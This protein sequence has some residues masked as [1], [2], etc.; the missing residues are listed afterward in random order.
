MKYSP[1]KKFYQ[2]TLVTT[3]AVVW[4]EIYADTDA[5]SRSE[6]TTFAVVWI[7]MARSLYPPASYRVTTFA[8]VWIEIVDISATI[9]ATYVTTF[10]VVW[11]EIRGRVKEKQIYLSPPSRWCGL[12]SVGEYKKSKFICHH[13]RGGVD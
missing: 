12:K 2:D 11:I 1:L 3:F 9:Q 5:K 13:L 10:A 4:I 6:V 8:V 7:E